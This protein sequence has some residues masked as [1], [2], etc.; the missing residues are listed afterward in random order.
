MTVQFVHSFLK[1][2][3]FHRFTGGNQILPGIIGKMR[4]GEPALKLVIGFL[5]LIKSK[6][7]TV[8]SDQAPIMKEWGPPESYAN[9]IAVC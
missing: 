8:P 2:R 4:N 7:D 3:I 5:E 1:T 6:T 9:A